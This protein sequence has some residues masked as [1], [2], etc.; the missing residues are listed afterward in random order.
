MSQLEDAEREMQAAAAL[1]GNLTAEAQSLAARIH[2]L[3]DHAN[4]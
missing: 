4:R 1:P 2:A 3:R